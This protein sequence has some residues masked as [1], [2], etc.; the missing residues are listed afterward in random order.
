[1]TKYYRIGDFTCSITCAEELQLPANMSLFQVPDT[2][3]ESDCLYRYEISIVDSLPDTDRELLASR[4]GFWVY[5][6]GDLETRYLG[7]VGAGSFSYAC[8]VECDPHLTR[9]YYLRSE[10][11]RICYDTIFCSL[12]SLERRMATKQSLVLHCAYMVHQGEAVL[13]SAPSETGKST[14]AELWRRFR[15]SRVV[16]GDRALIR[17]DS[18]GSWLAAGWPVCGSSEICYNEAAPIKAIVMLSQAKENTVRVV[19]GMEAFRLLYAQIT[20]NGWNQ[21]ASAVAMD[22]M[23]ALLAQVPMYHLACDISEDAVKCLEQV[24]Y[25]EA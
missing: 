8:V 18:T 9:V 24:L 20:V 16:N 7:I 1:M 21:Q 19:R 14:Q 17:Q 2:S 13:F 23:E 12:L 15:G 6:E 5:Q 10:L 3:C 11:Y 4:D 22:L 25:G